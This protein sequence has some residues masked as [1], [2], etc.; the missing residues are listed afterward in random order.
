MLARFMM[1][2]LEVGGRL[3]ILEDHDA[4]ATDPWPD[5]A[6]GNWLSN[7]KFVYWYATNPNSVDLMLDSGLGL[8]NCIALTRPVSGFGSHA[9]QQVSDTELTEMARAADHV[10]VD[11]FDFEGFVIWNRPG[12]PVTS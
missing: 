2:F 4:S 6:R 5:G 12:L 8:F 10:V 7:D 9:Q 11:A 3:A 1:Q